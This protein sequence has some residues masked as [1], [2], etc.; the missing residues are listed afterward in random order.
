MAVEIIKIE[1]IIKDGN[2]TDFVNVTFTVDKKTYTTRYPIQDVGDKQKLKQFVWDK[3]KFYEVKNNFTDIT[4]KIT[5]SEKDFE[6]PEQN[7]TPEQI[8]EM[9]IMELEKQ[10]RYLD[11]GLITQNE[12]NTEL[13]KVKDLMNTKE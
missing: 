2:T 1:K 5:I 11:L 10:K 12:Y 4:K 9:A 8:L 6:Q 13:S 3:A 7:E